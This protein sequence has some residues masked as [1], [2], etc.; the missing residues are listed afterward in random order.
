MHSENCQPIRLA[1]LVE[2]TQRDNGIKG[3]KNLFAEDN[4][5]GGRSRENILLDRFF[6]ELL[7]RTDNDLL[8]SEMK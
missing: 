8:V 5:R 6:F 1:Q 3:E 7:L 4:I 2:N